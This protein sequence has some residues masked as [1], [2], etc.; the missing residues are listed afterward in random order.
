MQ[1]YKKLFIILLVLLVVSGAFVTFQ[2][3]L[4]Y[5]SESDSQFIKDLQDKLTLR[6]SVQQNRS[7]TLTIDGH[8]H[9]YTMSQL[10]ERIYYEYEDGTTYEAGEE[11]ALAKHISDT[12]GTI[13]DDRLNLLVRCQCNEETVKKIM[14][15]LADTYHTSA[16]D[17]RINTKGKVVAAQMAHQL[18]TDTIYEKLRNYLNKKTNENY[19]ASYQTKTTAPVWTT[20]KIKRVKHIICSYS[21]SFSPSS[22]R[23]TNIKIAAS[24]L[25]NRFLLPGESISFL[26]VLYDDSDG[27]A[28]KKSGAY[29][30]G[31]VVQA[32]GGGICQVSSTAYAT[33][34][35]A[36]IIPEKRYPH[37]IPVGYAPLGLD[38]ALSVGGKDL[39][40]R[41][42][43][44]APLLIQAKT[45]NGRLNIYLKSYKNALHGY[46]YKPK[47]VELSKRKAKSYLD[48]YKGKKKVKT[49]FLSKDKYGKVTQ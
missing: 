41:N 25:D 17:S 2:M 1:R 47:S 34:L 43:L 39:Q 45:K 23:G 46:R 3:G 48:V 40:I 49:I 28:Y 20:K 19:T 11:E 21:T 33:F 30:K 12:D 24:R 10:G 27:K 7:V 14:K 15:E 36:G 42:T 18:N 44:D 32:T 6:A 26:D 5:R 9:S 35:F 37:S 16:K 8:K 29:F 38:A 31:K 4:R 13:S 22:S